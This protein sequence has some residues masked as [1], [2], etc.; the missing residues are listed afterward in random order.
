MEDALSG[1]VEVVAGRGSK[2]SRVSH[3]RRSSTTHY[4]YE[5]GMMRFEVSRAAY[6]AFVEGV[7]YRAYYAPHSKNLVNIE[8]GT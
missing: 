7:A 2:Y 1:R 6:H 4:Y 8:A 5:I 3:G